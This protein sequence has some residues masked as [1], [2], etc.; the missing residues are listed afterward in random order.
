[1]ETKKVVETC[2]INCILTRLVAAVT[3]AYAT[4]RTQYDNL[5]TRQDGSLI[6][7]LRPDTRLYSNLVL[8]AGI[9]AFWLQ[10]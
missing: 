7:K 1:M 5:F 3:T 6:W 9:T 4:V 8:S 2:G 10:L